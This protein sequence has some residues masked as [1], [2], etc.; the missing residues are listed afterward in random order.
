MPWAGSDSCCP[1]PIVGLTN[2]D[3]VAATQSPQILG[4][5]RCSE[6]NSI[7]IEQALSGLKPQVSRTWPSKEPISASR[8]DQPTYGEGRA[9]GEQASQDGTALAEVLQHHPVEERLGTKRP[10]LGDR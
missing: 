5:E 8:D 6:V 3:A 9:I 7:K 1:P 4:T 2:S 10:E